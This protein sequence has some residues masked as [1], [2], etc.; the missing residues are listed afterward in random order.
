MK[1]K[2]RAK[3]LGFALLGLAAVE[4]AVKLSGITDFPIYVWDSKIGY[5]PAV[6]QQGSFLNKNRWS[7]NDRHMGVSRNWSPSE[8]TNILLIGNSIVMGGNPYDQTEKLG[9]LIQAKLGAKAN[10]WPIAAG[11]WT[12]VNE[13]VYLDQNPDV[14]KANSFFVWEYMHGG[15]SQ[16]SV[17]RGQYVFPNTKPLYATWY[18]L[19]RYVIPKFID[20]NM[21][22]LPPSGALQKENLIAFENQVKAL[23]AASGKN[24]PG[25]LFFYP[26]KAEYE[27]FKQGVDY[28]SDR[29]ELMQIASRYHLK[30]VDIAKSP[31]W[32]E[33]QYREGTHPTAEGNKVLANI[34][35]AAIEE[36][37][38]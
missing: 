33:A 26:G 6:N 18:V 1:L 14:V 27:S 5:I 9:P 36:G 7:F 29:S 3:V 34:L 30:V 37:L 31:E 38:Q 13:T 21:N 15:L 24:T 32:S 8:N 22:E 17:N 11:G 4:G 25:I 23:S 12:N 28:V 10:V 35:T 19:R 20:L 2:H 16:L